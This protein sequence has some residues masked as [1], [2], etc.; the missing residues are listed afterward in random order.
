MLLQ[1]TWPFLSQGSKGTP[2]YHYKLFLNKTLFAS[3][4][5]E[6]Y[7]YPIPFRYQYLLKDSDLVHFP[8]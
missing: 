2:I 6:Y 1:G 7:V 5:D 8:L 3:L 4:L